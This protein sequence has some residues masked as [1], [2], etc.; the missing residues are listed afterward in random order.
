MT[1]TQTL[2][3]MLYGFVLVL[4]FIFGT[5]LSIGA[6]SVYQ[7]TNTEPVVYDETVPVI[8]IPYYGEVA[9][10]Y[11]AER[12]ISTYD[13]ASKTFSYDAEVSRDSTNQ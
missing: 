13:Y 1:L 7:N 10:R 3:Y 6:Q 5:G 2:K 12:A 8:D 11:L 4:V 9:G